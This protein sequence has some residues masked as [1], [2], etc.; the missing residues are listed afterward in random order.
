MISADYIFNEI[1]GAGAL[2]CG[3]HSENADLARRA[4]EVVRRG[5]ACVSASPDDVGTLWIWLEKNP[6]KIYGR[7]Y[8]PDGMG[9]DIDTLSDLTARINA[10]FKRGASGAQVF[11]TRRDLAAFADQMHTIRDD[12]FFNKDL[13]IGLDLSEIDVSDWGD[14]FA[15]LIKMRAS[16]VVFVL[17]KDMGKKS[18]FVGR[19]FGA[20]NA[21]NPAFRGDLHFAAGANLLR[22]EQVWRLVASVRPE[23]QKGARIF[24][25]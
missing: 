24:I 12:L 10:C 7:F 2:W 21:W 15:A 22:A 6:V 20:L 4:E 19:V 16:S 11:V 9:A 8:L 1:G 23:M 25:S 18:D 13:S 5:A 17:S 14:V 3:A